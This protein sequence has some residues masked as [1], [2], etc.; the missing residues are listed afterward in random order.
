MNQKDYYDILGAN[1]DASQQ[2][3][4][5]AYRKLAF[6]YHPDKNKGDPA[7]TEKMKDINEAYAVLSDISKRRDYDLLKSL[8]G[9]F[10]YERFRQSHTAADIFKD[11]DINQIFEEFAR[12]FGF[13]SSGDIFKESY[14]PEYR[15]FEFRKQGM[16]GRSFI[17][18]PRSRR[19]V[20]EQQGHDSQVQM[21]ALPFPWVLSKLIKFFLKKVIGVELPE[22]GKDWYDA[23][24]LSPEKARDGAEVEYS[25]KIWGKPKNLMV[26]IPPNVRDGQ[27]IRLRGMGFSGKSGGE[28]GDLYLQAQIRRSL[29]QRLKSLFKAPKL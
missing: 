25:Y 19:W 5:E 21:S 7:A 23:I 17:F 4:K 6:Q 24:T 2:A 26:K 29:T 13:R 1:R 22:R 3:I 18:N 16:F 28:P 15:N 14:G 8:Y 12:T 20:G 11:S 27:R 9:S 10:A